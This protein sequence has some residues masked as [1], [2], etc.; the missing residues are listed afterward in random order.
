MLL[1]LKLYITV[2]FYSAAASELQL[3]LSDTNVTSTV[4]SSDDG[5][6]Q[7]LMTQTDLTLECIS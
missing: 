2:H 1:I 7:N 4:Y 5:S 6:K 3:G